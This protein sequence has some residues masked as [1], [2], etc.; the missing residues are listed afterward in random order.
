MYAVIYQSASSERYLLT[1]S[2]DLF[3]TG[4]LSKAQA[5]VSFLAIQLITARVVKVS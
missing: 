5:A 2:G 3:R 4:S 1:A